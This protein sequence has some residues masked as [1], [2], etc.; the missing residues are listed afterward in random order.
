MLAIKNIDTDEEI[1]KARFVTHGHK[2]REKPFLVQDT[3][4]IRR[5]SIRMLVAIAALFGFRF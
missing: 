1:Y 2:D 5:S 4:K 3:T